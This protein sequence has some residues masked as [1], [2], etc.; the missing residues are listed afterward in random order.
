MN[1]TVVYRNLISKPKSA[2][3]EPILSIFMIIAAQAKAILYRTTNM[4]NAKHSPQLN[5]INEKPTTKPQIQL[6]RQM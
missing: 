4:P 5:K 6:C 3:D 1:W 2:S